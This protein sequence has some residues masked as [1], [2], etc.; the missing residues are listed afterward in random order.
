MADR[1]PG[2]PAD[3]PRH[4]T[5]GGYV[6]GCKEACCKAAEARRKKHLRM[7]PRPLVDGTGTHRRVEALACLGWDRATLSACLGHH[8][9]YLTKVLANDR[10]EAPTALAVARL[11][12]QLSMTPYAGPFAGRTKNLA[13]RRGAHPPLA[14]DNI[15]DPAEH[16]QAAAAAPDPADLVDEVVVRR[17]IAGD[18]VPTTRAERVEIVARWCASGRP[19]AELERRGWKPERYRTGVAA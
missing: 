6:A 9:D 3:D 18:D 2:L 12:D 5:R 19:L 16:P 7:H 15:D 13:R 1:T 17:F 11:Y 10:L 8:R 4:G 14:W